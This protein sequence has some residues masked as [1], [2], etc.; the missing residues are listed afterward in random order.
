MN[1]IK[2]HVF[3]SLNVLGGVMDPKAVTDN[4]VKLEAVGSAGSN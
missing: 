4:G 3:F 2:P 1:V